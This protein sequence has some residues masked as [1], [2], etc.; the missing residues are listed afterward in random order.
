MS[1]LEEGSTHRSGH[2]TSQS[3][4]RFVFRSDVIWRRHRGISVQVQVPHR[5]NVICRGV[6]YRKVSVVLGTEVGAWQGFVSG[7]LR[8]RLQET[9][10]N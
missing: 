1:S 10:L 8:R 2:S 7:F 3:A 9:K 4:P 6:C 5:K